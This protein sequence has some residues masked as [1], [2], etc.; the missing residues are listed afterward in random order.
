MAVRI[1]GEACRSRSLGRAVRAARPRTGAAVACALLA[2]FAAGCGSAG[3][4]GG[5][6]AGGRLPVVAAE[7]FWGSLAAQLGGARVQVR[8]IVAD[9]ATDPHSYEPTAADARALAG[10]QMAIVNGLGYDGW[11]SRLLN[12]SPRE[13]RV[14]LDVGRLLGLREGANPH[15]WYYPADVRAVIAAIAA[16]YA[17]LD[18]RDAA[19]FAARRRWLQTAGLARYDRLRAQIRSRYAGTPV[20]YSESIF[21]GL[22]E[23]L[24][25]RLATPEGFVRAIAEGGEVSAADRR[26][27]NR[28][29]E[30]REIALWV[31]NSQNATPDVQR[32]NEIARARAIP[33]ATVTET[34]TPAGDTFQQWQSAQLEGLA[35]ALRA[36]TGR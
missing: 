36:G 5:A 30:R 22:G 35:R 15:R 31:Y 26:T 28:Q 29:A 19:Y 23:D 20:G 24:R 10:A 7:D 2:A 8:S 25:L 18:P 12:A 33:V 9:P 17:R 16:D 14:V 3:G 11:A 34:L 32:V 13:G 1:Q 6:G 27:V 4:P 21:Q